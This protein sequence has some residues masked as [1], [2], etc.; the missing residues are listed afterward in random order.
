[1]AS[2]HPALRLTLE[3]LRFHRTYE[4]IMRILFSLNAAE[5]NRAFCRFRTPPAGPSKNRSDR[6][7]FTIGARRMEITAAGT[8]EGLAADVHREG[9]VSVPSAVMHGVIR[10]LPYFGHRRILVG[11]SEGKMCVDNVVFH[12]R[13]IEL[14]DSIPTRRGRSFLKRRSLAVPAA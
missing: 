11:F 12:N 8:S 3:D 14:S 7:A 6:I 2:E 5:M 9:R 4:E 1:M 13:M 10:T